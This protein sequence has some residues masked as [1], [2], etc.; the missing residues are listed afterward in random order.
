MLAVSAFR[1]NRA[2]ERQFFRAQDLVRREVPLQVF[3]LELAH[4]LFGL[5][6]RE[7]EVRAFGALAGQDELSKERPADC[8]RYPK[9]REQIAH[10]LGEEVESLRCPKRRG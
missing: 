10:A 5:G 4:F 2:S 9:V 3:L 8:L 1:A 7:N 6:R